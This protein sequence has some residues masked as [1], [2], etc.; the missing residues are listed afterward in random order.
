MLADEFCTNADP[1]SASS[2]T[3]VTGVVPDHAAAVSLL[4]PKVALFSAEESIDRTFVDML[5]Y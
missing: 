3:E 4:T 5:V 2:D 1:D